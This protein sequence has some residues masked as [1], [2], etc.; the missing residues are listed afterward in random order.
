M[1]KVNTL[2]LL[3]SKYTDYILNIQPPNVN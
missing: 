3:H 2:S 1:F